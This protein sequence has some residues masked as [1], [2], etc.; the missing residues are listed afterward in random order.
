MQC[1]TVSYGLVIV[2]GWNMIKFAEANSKLR[3]LEHKTKKKVYSFNILAGHTC[4]F[5]KDCRSKVIKT[6]KGLRIKD[7]PKCKFRCFAASLELKT[8]VYESHRQNS[9]IVK[10]S[11]QEI[12]LALLKAIPK[13][14][15]IIRIHVSGD[16]CSQKYFDAWL[17]VCEC[18]KDIVFYAYTK[19]LKF[20]IK[21]MEKIPANLCL[22]AS[23]GGIDDYLIK[24]Y[25]LRKA[26][27]VYHKN[28]TNLPIET[29]ETIVSNVRMK[30]KDVAL[31]IHGVQPKK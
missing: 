10:M 23:E 9:E 13:R 27:V 24:Q 15:K 29:N 22:T 17:E 20:W 7:G 8:V 11:K 25:K 2:W 16:F 3:K 26:V 5:A 30:N 31:V 19:A 4:P 21:R 12:V 28:E 1:I 18:R 6:K 14:A